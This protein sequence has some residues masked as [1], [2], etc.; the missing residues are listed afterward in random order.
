MDLE[1]QLRAALVISE[2]GPAPLEAVMWK[3][4]AG[5]RGGRGGKAKILIAS[6][7]LA[8]AVAAGMLA[9]RGSIHE[10]EP[11]SV[12]L[13]AAPAFDEAAMQ[14]PSSTESA[15]EAA[16]PAVITPAVPAVERATAQLAAPPAAHAVTV[17]VQPLQY[18]T[19]DP[20]ARSLL[21][22]YYGHLL[23]EL[24]AI[25]GLVLVDPEKTS[26]EATPAEFRITLTGR[27]GRNARI[28]AGRATWQVKLRSEQRKGGG[29]APTTIASIESGGTSDA[30]SCPA[31]GGHVEVCLPA[32]VAASHVASLR[33]MVLPRNAALESQLQAQSLDPALSAEARTRALLD[34]MN[35]KQKA[36]ETM[37]A[38]VI[39]S[40]LALAASSPLPSQRDLVWR[41]L[42][43][44]KN[45][46]LI[47]P[48]IRAARGEADDKTRFTAV[49]TLATDFSGDAAA[50]NA[51]ASVAAE[52]PKPLARKVAERAVAGDAPWREYVVAGV[53]DA[54]Q[55]PLQRVEPLVWMVETRRGDPAVQATLT[56]VAPEVLE[57]AGAAALADLLIRVHADR[58]ESLSGLKSQM[59][60]E[61]FSSV[62]HPA[63]PDLMMACFDGMPSEIT[64][65]FLGQHRDDARVADLLGQIATSHPEQKLRDRAAGYLRG[66]TE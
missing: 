39:G 18:E 57:R 31:T 16:Q 40:A 52:D 30:T 44:Q 4:S 1:Q 51:L 47:P 49:V 24:R 42:R 32:G 34:V 46:A 29:Y 28:G 65:H 45:P 7:L 56:S 61:F 50:R 54:N 27:D 20:V 8:L 58:T 53:K 10:V 43:G 12:V 19:D 60:V 6:S 48:L 36:G 55:P 15:D 63:V 22:E 66:S 5:P 9:W 14:P 59:L 41:Y 64:L 21:Q 25:P 33:S 2:P 26:G 23:R 13:E 38:E 37:D 62:A 3:L 11:V 35:R 17:L